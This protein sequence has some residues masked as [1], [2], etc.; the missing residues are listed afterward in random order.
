MISEEI[1]IELTDSWLIQKTIVVVI[2]INI[3]QSTALEKTN[4]ENLLIKKIILRIQIIGEKIYN[5]ERNN[6]IYKLKI[7]NAL[8]SEN[9][10]VY[11]N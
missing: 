11:C 4:R 1:F 9:K 8:L 3:I 6:S 5:Q 7:R 10:I 2:L